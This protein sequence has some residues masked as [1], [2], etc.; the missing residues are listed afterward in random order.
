MDPRAMESWVIWPT[1]DEAGARIVAYPFG[2][3]GWLS[4][5]WMSPSRTVYV[6]DLEGK[7]YAYPQSSLNAQPW[8][9]VLT[10]PTE[11]FIHGIWGLDDE[12]V[13]AWAQGREGPFLLHGSGSSWAR[14]PSPDFEVTLVR[15]SS[16]DHLL[17]LGSRGELARW[18]GAAWSKLPH[19]LGAQASGVYVVDKQR[20]WVC[21]ESGQLLEGRGDTLSERAR[22]PGSAPLADVTV[23]KGEVWLAGRELGLMKVVDGS[24][25]L[26]VVKPNINVTMFDSRAELLMCCPAMVATTQDG[27]AY[28]GQ[29]MRNF[30][31]ARAAIPP[32]WEP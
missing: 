20:Y 24:S 27:A 15:G 4:G 17:A 1:E 6:C 9:P 13:Y 28:R 32:D 30:A 12:N 10:L 31:Q 29:L 19:K 25:E 22:A 26:E 23:W 8:T 5:V 18:D 2:V 3:V 21:S 7:V 11:S 16:P 14:Q